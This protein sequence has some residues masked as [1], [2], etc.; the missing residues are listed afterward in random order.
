MVKRAAWS[1]CVLPVLAIALVGT[2]NAQD[3]NYWSTAYGTRSQL[4]GGVVI[5][6]PGDI[7]AVFYNPGALALA[8]PTEL[9]LAGNA[10]QYQ[11]VSVSNGSGPGR[12][13]ISSTVSAV[14]SLFAGE[15][16]LKGEDRFA[17][18]FITRRS[19]DMELERYATEGVELFAPIA[20]P[21]FAATEVQ[22]KQDFGETWYG[23]TWSHKLTPRIGLGVSPFVVVRSQNTRASVLAEGQDASGNAA[24]LT[25][26]R[27]YDFLHFGLLARIGLS[28]VRDSL[29]WGVTVTTANLQVTGSGSTQYNTT[30]IDQT[31]SIGNLIGAD[32]RKGLKTEYHTPFGAGAGASYGW[33]K[34]RIHAAVDW[35]G[36]VPRYTVL[37]TPAFTV[38]TPSGDSTVQAAVLD[39]V[40]SVL[41]W[42]LGIEHRFSP[43]WGGYASYHTD[44]SGHRE[45]DTP[46][47]SMTRW[48]LQDVTVGSTIR[49]GRSDFA[50]GLS[51]AFAN[52]P[53]V[54][55]P[56]PPP[57]GPA[58]GELKTNV[59]LVTV[60]VGWKIS[61]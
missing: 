52:R 16:P 59:L 27:E 13:L 57:G 3:S 39:Q 44:F 32:Y 34:S 37:E 1:G 19:M 29:T 14:P 22:L 6:S 41:N 47:L 21:V 5:G 54:R 26:S 4:L 60:V 17:Y 61:F 28:G 24:I 35:N 31:G 45:G 49:V 12:S 43:K 36:E 23:G 48:D 51:G 38:S 9:L 7:S 10:Y 42:G 53:V 55:V 50:L 58:Q 20:N 56:D 40:K 25:A 8:G 30:L 15:I 18:A 33:T 11:K 46:G 2:A